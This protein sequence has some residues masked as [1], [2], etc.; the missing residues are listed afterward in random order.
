MIQHIFDKWYLDGTKMKVF[1]WKSFAQFYC[2]LMKVLKI[3]TGIHIESSIRL[4]NDNIPF[5]AYFLNK[6]G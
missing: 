4:F 1:H 5:Y 2:F 3:I 6:L